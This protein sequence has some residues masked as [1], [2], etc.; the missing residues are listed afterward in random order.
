VV[1]VDG[2]IVKEPGRR[3]EPDEQVTVRGRALPGPSALRYL[4]LNKPVGVLTTLSDPE[5]RRTV[6]EF[7][8]PSP[9]LFPVGRLDGDT[10]GLLLLT[11]DG[12]LAHR[13]MHPRYGVRKVYR[14]RV[15]QLPTPDQLRRLRTGVTLEP[16]VRSAP[17][18]VHVLRGR[19]GR[20]VVEITVHEGRYHQVRRMCEV[21]GLDVK[22]LHRSAYGPLTLA[23]MARG[24]V[25]DLTRVEVARLRRESLRPAGVRRPSPDAT[26]APAPPDSDGEEGAAEDGSWSPFRLASDEERPSQRS[27]R[28][29]QPGSRDRTRQRPPAVARDPRRR[30]DSRDPRH[31]PEVRDQRPRSDSRDS[32]RGPELRDPRRRP[33][34]RHPRRGPEVRDPRRRPGAR[35]LSRATEVRDPRRRPAS[36]DSRGRPESRDQGR[37]LESRTPRGRHSGSRDARRGPE[38]RDPRRRPEAREGGRRAG[39]FPARGSGQGPRTRG[40]GDAGARSRG[41]AGRSSRPARRTAQPRGRRSPNR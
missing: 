6:R 11:N 28:E 20:A 24:D 37:G 39:S 12:E 23:K 19:E 41:P 2:R 38:S 25:R 15:S 26:N 10:S 3:V 32:R 8:P 33:E 16:G 35:D 13:L 22:A 30:P 7:L 14:A 31:G 17:A 5:G 36:R 34:S 9:R 21:V 27:T 40:R 18:Q 29:A 4:M 1:R